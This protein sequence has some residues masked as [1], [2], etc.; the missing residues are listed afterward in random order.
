[1]NSEHVPAEASVEVPDELPFGGGWRVDEGEGE[2][3]VFR[4]ITVRVDSCDRRVGSKS[5]E[6]CVG[7]EG[8]RK[9]DP[10]ELLH[11]LQREKEDVQA[12]DGC[13]AR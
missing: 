2:D 11:L 7:E 13:D 5:F 10:V 3:V 12:E 8:R 9:G 1:M 6:G 4:G